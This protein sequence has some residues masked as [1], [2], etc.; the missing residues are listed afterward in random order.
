MEHLVTLLIE[1]GRDFWKSPIALFVIL[2][3]VVVGLL[4]IFANDTFDNIDLAEWLI[5]VLAA[6]AVV[7]GW[8]YFRR[9]PKPARDKVGFGIAI[10]FEEPKQQVSVRSD[11]IS[12]LRTLL[13]QHD[14]VHQFELIEFS[15]HT[16]KAIDRS[17]ASK[18]LRKSQCR[19]L[20]FGLARIREQQGKLL[21][22]FDLS[23]IVSHA[24]IDTNKASQ[25]QAEFSTVL[26][27]RLNVGKDGDFFS[28]E[29]TARWFDII[30]R[31][32]VGVAAYHTR[33]YKYAE[34][35]LIDLEQELMGKFE[36]KLPA[37]A[38]IK[39]WIPGRLRVIYKE[40]ADIQSHRYFIGRDKSSLEEL[41][42]I[43]DKLQARWPKDKFAR[44]HKALTAFVLRRDVER[45]R[46]EIEACS[47]DAD[48]VWLFSLAFLDAYGGDLQA[49]YRNY[50]KAFEIP[51]TSNSVPLQVEEFIQIVMNEEPDRKDLLF[52]VG[53][54]NYRSKRDLDA[55]ERDFS[56]FLEHTEK[57]KYP[58]QHEAVIKWLGEINRL[59][60][61]R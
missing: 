13:S 25:L 38:H 41:E 23:G 5:A 40:M 15:Q 26:P 18:L 19:F 7:V 42:N 4:K 53:L 46:L 52:C 39:Q 11:L 55:A 33:D 32:I 49:A 35:L 51:L 30:T 43:T 8:A 45:A 6:I 29:F 12:K 50:C 56:E 1:K 58:R 9:I 59:Q 44:H 27:S 48:N 34:S 20:I 61:I 47:N 2:T 24:P 36:D 60:A 14:S 31:Y 37:I 16:C 21:H 3:V 28:F 54:V 17:S 22:V 10:E 57:N